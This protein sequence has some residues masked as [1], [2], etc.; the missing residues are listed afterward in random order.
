LPA[1]VD[2]NPPMG[3]RFG[4]SEQRKKQLAEDLK[5]RRAAQQ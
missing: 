5:R 3:E 1:P 4:L 2:T